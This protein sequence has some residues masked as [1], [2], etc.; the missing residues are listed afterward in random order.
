MYIT[1][2]TRFCKSWKIQYMIYPARYVKEEGK[3]KEEEKQ[4]RPRT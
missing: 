4:Q 2:M 1:A 3:E